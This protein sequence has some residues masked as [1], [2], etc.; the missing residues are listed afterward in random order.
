M[1]RALKSRA[2]GALSTALL[3]AACAESTAHSLRA[4]RVSAAAQSAKPDGPLTSLEPAASVYLPQAPQSPPYGRP[5][6]VVDL[7]TDEGARLVDARWRYVDVA[8]PSAGTHA[9]GPDL[10]PSGAPITSHDVAPKIGSAAFEQ[11][12]WASVEPA[13]LEARRGSSKLS[14]GWYRAEVTI[15][16]RIGDFDP[17]GASVAFE[18]TVDDYAEVYVDGKLGARL[19]QAGRGVVG[20]FNTPTRV[21]LTRDARPGSVFQLAVFAANGPLSSP[22]DNFVW[23]RSATL[24]FHGP[25]ARVAAGSIERLDPGLDRLLD[26]DALIEKLATGFLFTEGPVWSFAEQALYFSDPNQNTIYRYDGALDVFRTKSGYSGT[27]IGEYKQPGSNGL[28]FDREGRLTINEHGNRRVTR[29]EKNGVVTVLADRF[30]GKRLNSPNDL[31]YKSDGSLYFTDP[32]FGLPRVFDD[33]RKELDFSGVFR[34]TPQGL[35]LLSRELTGPNGIAFSPDERFLYVANWDPARKVVLR[36]PLND[37]GSL[38][39]FSTFFESAAPGAEALDGLEVDE[40]GNVYVSV[41]GG[42]AILSADG[43]QLGT[44]RPSER[45]A[46]FAWGDADQR[47]LYMTA[48]SGLYRVRAKV[49]GSTAHR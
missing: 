34:W 35:S 2:I 1:T 17:T 47:T 19:G 23:V 18:I 7:M 44:L 9:P 15:P 27:N 20:G 29:L 36:F 46:N 37:D 48:H 22:P 38:G 41:P 3:A 5:R 8:L 45:P 21:V 12:Q 10:K 32:P 4:E 28:A 42:V 39:V 6:A 13:A 24:D 14:F 49:A 26:A 40:L 11:A 31:V 33:P 43:K 16:V 25:A 30:Q